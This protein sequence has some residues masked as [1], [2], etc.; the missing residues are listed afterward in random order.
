MA[1]PKRKQSNEHLPNI[2][3]LQKLRAWSLLATKNNNSVEQKME[4]ETE[5]KLN[6]TEEVQCMRDQDGQSDNNE[7][8][9]AEDPQVPDQA[10]SDDANTDVL[11]AQ[12]TLEQAKKYLAK[13]N[14]IQVFE[15]RITRVAL[16]QRSSRVAV[17]TKDAFSWQRL[18]ESCIFNAFED[19][20]SSHL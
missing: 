9:N 4:H 8:Q 17:V 13:H 18:E 3:H 16:V 5:N 20:C 10:P 2:E 19:F 11:S 12:S 6:E 14:I 7:E 1:A 15:V